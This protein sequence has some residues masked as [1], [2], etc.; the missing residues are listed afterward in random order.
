MDT[1][2]DN[3]TICR[4]GKKGFQTNEEAKKVAKQV[5][6]R[7]KHAKRRKGHLGQLHA[8]QCD[9]SELWH[10]GHVTRRNNQ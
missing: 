1:Y 3:F 8:Y 5:H 2:N 6:G 4:C 9:R 10:V 7:N